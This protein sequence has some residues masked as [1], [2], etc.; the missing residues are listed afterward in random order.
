MT[1]V[2]PVLLLPPAGDARTDLLATL[3]GLLWPVQ[4]WYDRQAAAWEREYVDADR[5][6]LA[7]GEVRLE[8]APLDLSLANPWLDVRVALLQLGYDL[9][10]GDYRV[11]CWP[12]GWRGGPGERYAGW[13]LGNLSVVSDT[14]YELAKRGDVEG[15]TWGLA[16]EVAHLLVTSGHRSAD[17]NPP[18][19]LRPYPGLLEHSVLRPEPARVA[20][21]QA[22]EPVGCELAA[23]GPMLA[24]DGASAGS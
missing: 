22:L 12:A 9:D 19:V 16:H 15:A 24:A 13:S 10:G 17:L 21:T 18:D 14:W 8:T 7:M 3:D 20:S 4:R 11:L 23:L 6:R 1:R 2:I 5:L